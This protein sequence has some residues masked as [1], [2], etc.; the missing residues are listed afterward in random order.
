M[1]AADV[2]VTIT[3]GLVGVLVG[4]VYVTGAPLAVLVAEIVPHPGEQAAPPCVSVQ[5][6]PVLFVPVT[7]AVNACAWPTP[8]LAVEGETEMLTFCVMVIIADADMVASAAEVAVSVTVPACVGGVAGAVYAVAAPLVVLAGEIV[9]HPGEQAAPPCVSA[10]VT[11]VLG[12]PETMAINAWLWPTGTL[13][14]VGDTVTV[15]GRVTEVFAAQPIRY[16][17]RQRTANKSNIRR[18]NDLTVDWGMEFF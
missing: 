7:V 17:G 18:M 2:A 9:P 10:Q 5:F 14:A 12:V 16:R 6:T 1:S 4:A 13:A 3:V 11:P 8:T 15:M